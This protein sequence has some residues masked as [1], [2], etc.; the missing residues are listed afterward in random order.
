MPGHSKIDYLMD[1]YNV[2]LLYS[3]FDQ[4][5]MKYMN[6]HSIVIYLGKNKMK[7]IHSIDDHLYKE[8]YI[9]CHSISNLVGMLFDINHFEWYFLGYNFE[10][11]CC[12]GVEVVLNNRNMDC[13]FRE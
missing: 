10:R 9:W 5:D 1:S 11:I 2:Q 12:F 4:S 3:R 7:W 8:G 13:L 6:I